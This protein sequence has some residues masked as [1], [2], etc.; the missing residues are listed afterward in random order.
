M[1]RAKPTIWLAFG[2]ASLTVML[3]IVA[4]SLGIMPNDYT[5]ELDARATVAEALAVQMADAASRNDERTLANT[6]DAVVER[7]AAVLSAALRGADGAVLVERGDHARHWVRPR[8]GKSTPTHVNVPLHGAEGPQGAIEIVFAPPRAGQGFMGVPRT[9]WLFILFIAAGGFAGYYLLL[10]RT[11]KQLDPARVVPERVQRA[12]D[13]LSEG[14][15]ILDERERILLVNEAFTALIGTTP[16]RGTDINKLSWRMPD[17]KEADGGYV[18]HTAIREAREIRGDTLG[19]RTRGGRLHNLTVGAAPIRGENERIMGAIVTLGDMTRL[20]RSQED[21]ARTAEQLAQREALMTQQTQELEYLATHDTLSGCLNRRTFLSRLEQRLADATEATTLVVMEIDRFREIADEHGPAATDRLIAGLGALVAA[22]LPDGATA[23]RHRGEEFVLALEGDEAAAGPLLAELRDAVGREAGALL[24]GHDGLEVSFGTAVSQ[25]PNDSAYDMLGRADRALGEREGSSAAPTVMS[26]RT[27]APRRAPAASA[28]IAPANGG[29]AEAERLGAFERSLARSVAHAE[30]SGRPF[31][32]ARLRIASYDYLCEALGAAA[33]ERLVAEAGRRVSEI[34]RGGSDTL[35]LSSTGDVK[36]ELAG[37]DGADDVAFALGRVMDRLREPFRVAGRDVYVA[38]KIGAA[39][40]PQD[41][42]DP[43]TL[44]RHAAVALR[45]AVEEGDLESLRFY[46]AAMTQSSEW[47]MNV[48]SGIREA[49]ANDQF[50]LFFQPIVCA[51]TGAVAAAEALLRCTNE[52][53]EGVRIDQ[54]ID[55]AEQSTLSEEIDEWVVHRGLAQM[56]AWCDAGLSLPKVSLNVSAR[57]LSNVAFMDR[58]HAAVEAV[59]FSP[60][61][62]Q[63]EVTET[64]KLADVEVAAP[65]LKR[66]QRLGVQIAL[67]DFGTG[68]ASLTYLQRLHP[69]T[70]KID[71]SFIRGVTVNHAN[72]TLVAAMTVMAHCLGVRV[73]VEGVESEEELEFLRETRCDEVQG[74]LV[75]RPLPVADMSDWLAAFAGSKGTRDFV[76]DLKPAPAP[77]A[78]AAATNGDAASAA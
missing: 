2:L 22:T 10:R 77:V 26:A 38:A 43:D 30:A 69:D 17:G 40:F 52:R 1:K 50:E 55:V 6:L 73:V 61:R 42:T 41:G 18:W 8:G 19:L 47:R 13:T 60:T 53:L 44:L 46:D 16:P 48:E 34:L 15:V 9:V 66:L 24:P 37:L 75:S 11:L 63:I 64:A 67:D 23:G 45:R 68:Q 51:Q 35:V 7:N 14:V 21:L 39:M 72:A 65:Q 56:Q 4:H 33:A 78:T 62:V 70:L 12:F 32:V 20:K 27:R 5:A 28:A 3:A 25:G 71:R 74:Y 29:L 54:I 59:R 49:L 31:A 36:M 57:Q 58:V 76:A